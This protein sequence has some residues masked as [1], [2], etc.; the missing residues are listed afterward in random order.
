LEKTLRKAVERDDLEE[1]L[2]RI[3]REEMSREGAPAGA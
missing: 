1:R 2:R 3:I